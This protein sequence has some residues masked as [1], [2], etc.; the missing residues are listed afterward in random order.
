VAIK[1]ISN[2]EKKIVAIL[3]FFSAPIKA[4]FNIIL[5]LTLLLTLLLDRG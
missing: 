4:C 5:T 1:I 3:N 2:P